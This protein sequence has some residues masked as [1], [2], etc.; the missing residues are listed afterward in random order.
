MPEDPTN[1]YEPPGVKPDSPRALAAASASRAARLRAGYRRY[2]LVLRAL[3]LVND[4]GFGLSL[5][6]IA[7]PVWVLAAVRWNGVGIEG[8]P[9]MWPIFFVQRFLFFPAFAALHFA[10]GRGLRRLQPWARSAQ[11]LVSALVVLSQLAG[12]ALLPSGR[13][14]VWA[15]VLALLVVV[16]HV[17]ILYVLAS[18]R[19][20]RVVSD[21][22]RAVVEATSALK[23][24]MGWPVLAGVVVFAL[25][26][27]AG[28]M[29]VHQSLAPY[30]VSWVWPAPAPE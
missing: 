20:A 28:V 10:L 27:N 22:Y 18:G 21:R 9:L 17:V 24:R 14:P 25:V 3:G 30:L 2:E 4:I 8:S 26:A 29:G 12:F 16:A 6:M 1:P 23:P 11:M 13:R 15:N 19:G 5:V 7:G